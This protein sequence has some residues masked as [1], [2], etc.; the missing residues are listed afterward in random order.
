M[1]YSV[2]LFKRQAS[3]EADVRDVVRACDVEDAISAFMKGRN[4][5]F[6][7]AACVYPANKKSGKVAQEWRWNIQCSVS[8]KV[9]MY[10]KKPE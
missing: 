9:R 4:L 2:G 10:D 5:N 3:K 8:G 7:Y 6:A 1:Q